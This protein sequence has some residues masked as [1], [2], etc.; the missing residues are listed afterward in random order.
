MGIIARQGIKASIVSLVGVGI[1]A[2]SRLFV[3]TKFLTVDEI[4]LIDVVSKLVLLIFTFFILSSPQVIRKYYEKFKKEGMESSFLYTYV[5]FTLLTI[6]V[7]SLI[8]WIFKDHIAN[9]YSENA[10]L[11]SDYILLPLICTIAFSIFHI[12]NSISIINLRIVVPSFLNQLLV[13]VVA[14]LLILSYGYFHFIDQNQFINLYLISIYTIPGLGLL[15]YM[16]FI[17]KPKFKKPTSLS[18]IQYFFGKT[19]KYSF[20]LILSATSSYIV[21]AIDAQ[22]IGVKLGLASA[23]VYG[24]V[25]YMGNIIELPRRSI[26]N[27]AFP[28]LTKAFVENKLS[29]IENIYRESSVKQFFVGTFMFVMIW[30][31]LDL[32][33]DII[34]N[35]DIYKA[36][37]L[38]FVYIGIARLFD[39]FTGVNRQI[40][41]AS[42]FY[43]FNLIINLTLSVLVVVLNLIFI[44][45]DSHYFGGINGAAFASF[46]A[47][48]IS[49]FLAVLVIKLKLK[50][51]LLDINHLYILALMCVIIAFDHFFTADTNFVFSILKSLFFSSLYLLF[52]FKKF[53]F[54]L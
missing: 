52:F 2:I 18:Q 37:K 46:M 15:L 38:V 10:P 1:G 5:L 31:N 33:F 16:Y 28:I 45:L 12:L 53:N 30:I 8:Y 35:G 32:I 43:Y 6:S 9:L 39:L 40:I 13:R 41:E 54:K 22:M 51:S 3:A 19:K 14:I 47:I 27:I 25:F 21:M 20:F 36:G 24:V 48:I 34:P 44:P 29:K 4:G 26:S 7:S 42:N 17:I 11:I 49:N 23:G 50:I